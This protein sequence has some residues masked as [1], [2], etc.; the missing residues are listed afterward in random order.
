[1]GKKRKAE[2]APDLPRQEKIRRA[3]YY[4]KFANSSYMRQG[5]ERVMNMDSYMNQ[6][7][8]YDSELSSVNHAVW[9]NVNTRQTVTSFR[10]T[11]E[12]DDIPTDLAIAFG[13]EGL[14]KRAKQSNK[15]FENVK[16]KYTGFQHNL[17]GHSLG[18]TINKYVYHKNRDDIAN[19]YNYNEGS[20][21]A[22]L[23]KSILGRIIG[24]P[25]EDKIF[26]FHIDKEPISMNSFA[27][28]TQHLNLKP[29]KDKGNPHSLQ[30]FFDRS[31]NE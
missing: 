28:Y 1:M 30:Q 11:K 18:A 9:Y 4:A 22:H 27:D 10:G 6:G 31:E 24:H 15:Q 19:V 13:L 8:Q 7:W 29:K 23:R 2:S 20:S 3:S 17:S 25:K 14:T 26:T 21:F 12:L 16:N 5:D